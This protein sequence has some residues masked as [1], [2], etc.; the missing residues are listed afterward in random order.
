MKTIAGFFCVALLLLFQACHSVG[1]PDIVVSFPKTGQL[2]ATVQKVPVPFLLPRFMGIMGD[3]VLVYKEK[4]DSLFQFFALPEGRYVGS[5]GTRGQGPDEFGMPDTRGFCLS[6]TAFCLLEAGSNLL[7]TVTYNDTVVKVTGVESVLPQ[8]V[9]NIGFYPLSDSVCLTLGSLAADY[10][11]GLLNRKSQETVC[12]G[13]FPDWAHTGAE[14]GG[15][16]SFFTYIKTCVVSPDRKRFAAFYGYFKRF[17]IYDSRVNLLH[18]V[19]VRVEPYDTRF[20]EAVESADRPVYYIGQ[21]QATGDYIYALCSNATGSRLTSAGRPELH[22]F[23][24][25]GRPVA[26]YEFDRRVSLFAISP[27]HKLLV[28]LDNRNPDELYLYDLPE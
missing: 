25:E 8:G 12:R 24:W 20:G 5:A 14:A 19:E 17:R 4:E 26:C 1:Q 23:D 16:P 3:R 11:Y 7:K 15:V 27:R 13:R 21:P 6:D 9:S 18:D 2:H 22:V 28:A 10:E